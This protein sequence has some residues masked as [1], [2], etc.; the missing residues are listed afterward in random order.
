[1]DALLSVQGLTTAIATEQ[2]SANAVDN[3]SLHVRAGERVALVG[4]SGCG[5][6][7]TALSLMRLTRSP[8]RIVGG[9]VQLHGRDLFGASEREMRK[10][11]GGE[12]AMIF[13]DPL[14]FLNPLMRAGDQI[15]EAIVLHR[16]LSRGEARDLALSVLRLVHV[17]DPT[18]VFSAYPHELSGGMRQRVLIAMAVASRPALLIADEPTTALDVTIQAQI[19]RLLTELQD[20]LGTALLLITHDLG[21]V[22]EYCDRVYVMYAGQIVEHAGVDDLF[23]RPAHPYTKALLASTLS[24]EAKAEHLRPIDGQPPNLFTL[25][26]GCRFH[27][28]CSRVMEL[29]RT[30]APPVRE[31]QG[32]QSRCWLE[33]QAA[34]ELAGAS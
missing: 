12:L 30:E 10:L 21:L 31:G 34:G 6:S 5:K 20:E 7:M 15:V 19:M 27:P 17:S 25:P 14:T 18:R 13:Q 23:E 8:A 1:M 4:E 11:R 2:G 24:L 29:C 33:L 9:R 26:N 28:R 32:R 22:A 3:V 16:N